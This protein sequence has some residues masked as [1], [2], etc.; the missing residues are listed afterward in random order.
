MVKACLTVLDTMNTLKPMDI[1]RTTMK[2]IIHEGKNK[3]TY[4]TMP[5][6]VYDQID[7]TIKRKDTNFWF[8]YMSLRPKLRR[9]IKVTNESKVVNDARQ[10]PLAMI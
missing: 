3:T 7:E 5:D 8:V 9:Y 4:F 1:E 2:T 10:L 6:E